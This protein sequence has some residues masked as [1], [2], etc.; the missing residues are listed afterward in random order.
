MH[1]FLFFFISFYVQAL[2]FKSFVDKTEIGL[3]ETFNLVLEIQTD[4]NFPRDISA[5]KVFHLK[6][7]HFL[8]ESLSKQSSISIING[9]RNQMRSVIKKYRLQAKALG[10]FQIPSLKVNVDG[11]TFRTQTFKI[12]VLADKKPSPKAPNNFFSFPGF[13]QP[14]N[15]FDFPDSLKEGDFKLNLELSKNKVYK[16]E[17]VRADWFLLFTSKMPRY[18][19]NPSLPLQGFWKEKVANSKA[20]VGE[21]VIGNTLYR[22]QSIHSLWLFPLKTGTLKI[23]PYSIQLFSGLSFQSQ[24]LSAKR[25][26]IR[27]KELPLEGKDST[28]TGAV[29]QFKVDFI[30]EKKDLILN[31][32]FSFKIRFKGSGHPRFIQL[33]SLSFPTYLQAYD[34]IQKSN[35]TDQ[36]IGS[37]EFEI[38]LVPKKEG[39]FKF[40]YFTLSTFDPQKEQYIRHKSPKFEV[41]VKRDSQFSSQ[42]NSQTFFKLNES[43]NTSENLLNLSRFNWPSFINYKNL[44]YFFIKYFLVCCLILIFIKIKQSFKNK[45]QSIKKKFYI[46]LKDIEKLLNKKDWKSACIEMIQWNVFILSS[47]Q[48]KENSSHWRQILLDIPSSLDKRY[49]REFEQLFTDL[50]KLS[51]SSQNQE[52]TQNVKQVKNLFEKTKFLSKEILSH[53]PS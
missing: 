1:F 18:E 37:K 29:G 30:L 5:P 36:G 17:L 14:F 38:V 43:D 21:K 41:L 42:S 15:P 26:T 10:D 19:L 2:E 52:E 7:F 8:N 53:Y 27:V 51:F 24:T 3:N 6:D 22:K 44:R 48:V 20:I 12:K 32:P 25:K 35:F 9:Q 23:D 47:F 33:P 16:S 11:Q 49:T 40:P 31:Q 13:S 50:E 46:K 4:K 34:P 45:K 39:S 28:F